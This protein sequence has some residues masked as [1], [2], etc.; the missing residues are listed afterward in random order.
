M[1]SQAAELG[2]PLLQSY[3]M[4]EACSQIATEPLEHLATGFEPDRLEVLPCW[5]LTTDAHGTLTVRGAALASGYA[6]KSSGSWRWDPIDA[7]MG[8]VTRDRVQLLE[9]GTRRFLRFLGREGSFVKVL[10]ELVN[11]AALQARLE[12]VAGALGVMPAAVAALALPDARRETRL[13]LAGE[14]AIETLEHLRE[15]FNASSARYEHLESA[16]AVAMLPRTE[17]GKLD[18]QA[19]RNLIL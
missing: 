6:V 16:H 2:W 5:D 3:G 8:L 4:T 9:D 10:G 14:V 1:G 18:V 7:P 15:A 19:A 12:S 13:V 11:M 17:L